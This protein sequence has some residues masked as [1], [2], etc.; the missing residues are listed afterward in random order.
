MT[1]CVLCLLA[2]AASLAVAAPLEVGSQKQVFIDQRFIESS[3]GVKLVMN[4][5]RKLGP[6]MRAD[7]PWEASQVGA[8]C[9]IIREGDLFRMWYDCIAAIRPQEIRF[10]AYATSSDGITWRKNPLGVFE[11]NGNRDNNILFQQTEGSVFIDPHG[12]P[13]ERYKYAGMLPYKGIVVNTSPD[14]IHWKLGTEPVLPFWCDSQAVA[15]WDERIGKY[16]AYVRN[17]TPLRAV[18]RAETDDIMKPWPYDANAEPSAAFGDSKPPALGRQLPVVFHYDE[19]DPPDSDHYTPCVIKYPFAADAYFLFTAAY[20]HYPGPPAGKYN[21]DGPLEIQLATS[22]DGMKWERLDRSAFIPLGEQGS[23]EEGCLY[24]FP[25]LVRVGDELWLYYTGYPLTH[26]PDQ[27]PYGGTI[28]RVALRLDGFVAAAFD[29]NGGSLTTPLL[30]FAG[31]RL[32][33]NVDTGAMGSAQVELLGPDGSPMPGY[34]LTDCDRI[35]GNFIRK[36]VTWRGQ[37][38]INVT[39]PLRLRVV[40]RDTDLYAFQFL[41]AT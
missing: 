30:A 12:K 32:E 17:W 25:S 4:K 40:A 5:P 29:W 35:N 16:A 15:F 22:R 11:F 7:R 24:A 1:V 6:V 2:V 3:R 31:N 8:Y 13:E 27:P 33:L 37:A 36:T 18:S 21:N 28:R 39:G 41:P 9:T 10:V 23:G 26:G 14:G 20:L 38:E 34:A 19:Q